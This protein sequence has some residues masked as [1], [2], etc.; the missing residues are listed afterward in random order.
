M[1]A[2]FGRVIGSV[3]V[4]GGVLLGLSG[5]SSYVDKADVQ[6]KI[7]DFYRQTTSQ[8]P[9]RTECP[10]D[11]PAE[12]GK[13]IRCTVTGDGETYGVTVTATKVEGSDVNFDMQVDQ[14]PQ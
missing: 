5:C 11:L 4:A 12:V 8:A 13:S 9:D 1:V 3:V 6:Q 7:T 14:N 2:R 10:E